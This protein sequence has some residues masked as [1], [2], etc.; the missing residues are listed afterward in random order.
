MADRNLL[1]GILALQMDFIS[2]EQLIAAMNAWVLDKGKALGDILVA[3]QALEPSRRALLGVLVEEHLR[4]HGN[5]PQQSLAAISSIRSVHAELAQIG[6]ADVEHSLAHVA[7]QYDPNTTVSLT[8]P[9]AAGERYRILRP[10]AQGGLGE[11]FVADDREL[12]RDVELARRG[13]QRAALPRGSRSTAPSPT[14]F[15]ST[16]P[17]Q[18]ATI[19][20]GN[21]DFDM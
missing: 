10:H 15:R 21:G 9:A 20:L 8:T 5:D 12:H 3:Q 11:V 7:S 17:P 14:A 18:R 16:S 1:F 2:R 13:L 6:D 19:R 4:Q